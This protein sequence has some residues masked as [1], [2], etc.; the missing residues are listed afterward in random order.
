MAEAAP[1][2]KAEKP[3]QQLFK[4]FAHGCKDALAWPPA[5]IVLYRSQSIKAATVKCVVLNGVIF[6]GSLY[7]FNNILKPILNWVLLFGADERAEWVQ[8][9]DPILST[10]YHV[11]WVY[12]IY[13][14]SFILNSI[15]YQDIADKAYLL[16][17]GKPTTATNK[18]ES[19][20]QKVSALVADEFYR[21]ALQLLLLLQAVA[22]S[23]IP[24]LGPPV[25]FCYLSW[26]YAM[27]C[28]E[29]KWMNKGW[30]L[31]RRL[32]YFENAWAYFLG[33]GFPGTCCTFFFPQF[34]SSGIF[35]VIFPSYVIMANTATPLTID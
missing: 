33:F 6:L 11:L 12:P 14:M 24:V 20:L 4:C 28:F 32:D 2:R 30:A 13:C 15:W 22:I 3:L 17:I 5:L 31:E 34:V 29:Y 23:F 35:A 27:Y 26:L 18:S 21:A 9:L 10:I 19:M 8:Y 1:A 25:S 16:Q 7:F